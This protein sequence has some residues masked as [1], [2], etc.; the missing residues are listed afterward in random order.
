MEASVFR[1]ALTAL[2]L[3]AI[4]AL[5]SSSPAFADNLHLCD[6]NQF[7]TCNSG[8]AIPVTSSQAWAF[9][10]QHTGDTL[11]LAVMNPVAGGSGNFNSGT[12]LW[13]ALNVLP[14]QVFPNL[15]STIS[16]EQGATG[17]VAGSFN[18]SSFL[19]GA[20]T[21]TVNVGQSVIL[22][23][24]PVGTIYMA[25]LLDSSGNLIA[26]TPWSSAL[27]NVGTSVAEPSSLALLGMGLLAMGLL[28]GRSGLGGR[29]SDNNYGTALKA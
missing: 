17:I 25:Y 12:N 7:T 20:W 26:V 13:A 28:I 19:V 29:V 3:M 18:A 16:Q 24:G 6:V 8:S 9:G 2:I 22:P 11:Y 14:N 1:R 4:V 27:I 5:F 15:A 10:T 21:G 23:S